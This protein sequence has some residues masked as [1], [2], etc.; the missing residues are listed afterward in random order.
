GARPGRPPRRPRR[1]GRP[2][3]EALGALRPHAAG[4]SGRGGGAPAARGRRGH[5]APGARQHT[6]PAGRGRAA[7]PAPRRAVAATSATGACLLSMRRLV[8]A[9]ILAGLG[10]PCAPVLGATVRVDHSRSALIY[11][12]APGERN[13][14]RLTDCTRRTA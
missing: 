3:R 12:A 13:N 4:D 14:R 8:L 2:R 7:R 11:R 1:G 10:V 9:V 6:R 5:A